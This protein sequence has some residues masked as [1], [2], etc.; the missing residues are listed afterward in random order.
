M[1]FS[2]VGSRREIALRLGGVRDRSRTVV[3]G[4]GTGLHRIASVWDPI[5]PIILTHSPL[6]GYGSSAHVD[7]VSVA[8]V[9][10]VVL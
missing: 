7:G 4:Y 6:H 5:A 9:A 1:Q 2:P 3:H 8:A 10:R